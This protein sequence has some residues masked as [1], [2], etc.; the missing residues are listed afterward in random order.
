MRGIKLIKAAKTAEKALSYTSR[1]NKL[2]FHPKQI[3]NFLEGNGESIISAHI[4]PTNICNLSCDYCNQALRDKK[5]FL[6][7]E[8]IQNFVLMLKERGLKAAIITG[9]G[10]PTIY[11]QFNKLINWLDDNNIETA[12]ITN[13]TNDI[14][15]R[16]K[17]NVWDKFTWIRV[18]L[19]FVHDKLR[20]VKVPKIKGDLGFSMVYQGQNFDAI[21][22]VQQI[23][24]DSNAKYVRIVADCTLDKASV[25]K[26]HEE[27]GEIVEKLNDQ[28]FFIQ[29][30][31]PAQAIIDTC[32]QSK[33]RPFLLPTGQV[34]P[35]DCF[36]LNKDSKGNPFKTLPKNFNLAPNGPISYAEY[37]DG[38]FQP[39]FHPIKTCNSCAFV[40]T[41]SILDNLI[42]TKNKN[43]N[44]TIKK[45][46]QLS[47]LFADDAINH[48]NFI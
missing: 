44:A 17:I 18:S 1:G 48:K 26:N 33:L 29:N 12:L 24:S 23:A 30:K 4:A 27:L 14:A 7:I 46:F 34:A 6:D 9:G 21:K 13:G 22:Q 11:P 47:G 3:N 2:V 10:E 20:P 5:K 25:R 31:L 35:C 19:N 38:K 37:L 16:E 42:T 36:M 40:N 41:N 43:Q 45:L 15:G 8:T 28:R 32:H 39:K